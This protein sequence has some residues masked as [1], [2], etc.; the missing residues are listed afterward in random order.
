[1][2]KSLTASVGTRT[3]YFFKSQGKKLTEITS[4]ANTA[5]ELHDELT[6]LGIDINGLSLV[7]GDQDEQ[8]YNKK[9]TRL[10]QGDFTVFGM[11]QKQSLG[12][13]KSYP[14][15]TGYFAVIAEIKSGKYNVADFGSLHASNV[16][17]LREKLAKKYKAAAKKAAKKT[18]LITKNQVL[19]QCRKKLLKLGVKETASLIRK[20]D[21]VT[22]TSLAGKSIKDYVARAEQISK[23]DPTLI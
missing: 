8:Y 1:M 4:S 14:E 18:T 9:D 21:T 13:K 19:A 10:P 5:G 23:N 7:D 15:S 20:I 16:N 22:D 2:D 17:A 11:P 6:Q 3:I 12:T